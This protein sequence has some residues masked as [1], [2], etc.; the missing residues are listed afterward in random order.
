MST[1]ANLRLQNVN[2]LII[3]NLNINSLPAK[4]DQLKFLLQDKIDILVLTETKLDASFPSNQFL[5]DGFSQPY[6]HDRNRNGG[7][8]MIYIREGI[9]S[10]VLTQHNFPDDIEGIYLE[11]NLRKTKW[12][13]LGT[14]HP[15]SQ[16]DTYYFENIGKFN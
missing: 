9:P 3:G 4:F 6:R 5:I 12:L 16:N 14:Y 13:L 1:L 2:K 11:I 8:V 15:P 10:K 7:G